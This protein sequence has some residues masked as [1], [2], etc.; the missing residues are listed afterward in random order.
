MVIL[1]L[2]AKLLFFGEIKAASPERAFV[3]PYFLFN[4]EKQSDYLKQFISFF[5]TYYQLTLTNY[6]LMCV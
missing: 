6:Y 1:Y 2:G 4:P 3:L 5:S